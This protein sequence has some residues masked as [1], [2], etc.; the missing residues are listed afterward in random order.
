MRLLPSCGGLQRM[1][2]T[3]P[4]TITLHFDAPFVTFGNRVTQ[5][6][7]ASVAYIHPKRYTETVGDEGVERHPVGTGPWRFVEHFPGQR[8][9]YEAVTSHW[10]TVPHFQRLVFLRV[11]DIAT[12]IAML[13]AGE[14]DVIEMSGE[15]IEALQ[16]AGLRTLVMPNVAWVW[17][18]LGGQ[19]P[20]RPTYDPTVPWA[21]PD[22][23]RAR[24]VRL[25]LNLAIDKE[26][27]IQ[28]ILGGVGTP[29]G[30]VNFTRPIPGQRALAQPYPYDPSRAKAILAEAGY[31][32]GFPITMYLTAWPGRGYL[33]DVGEAVA[34]YW[35]RIGLKVTRRPVDRAVFA[36]DFR[37][38]PIQEWPW[39]TRDLF[40]LLSPGNCLY[41]LPTARPPCNCSSSIQRS[42][43]W[44]INSEQR[45]IPASGRESCVKNLAPAADVYTRGQYWPHTRRG[46]VGPRIGAWPLI[47]GHT[48]LH[49]WEYVTHGQ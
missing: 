26:A 25:A 3:D 33:P 40:S 39:R 28:Q 45:P 30:T 10:R 44:S 11:P 43:R 8:I 42:M 38:A 15:Y 9:V 2:V 17:V 18:V 6:L 36:N 5:G 34:S 46:G 19:W 41:V 7:F 13:R 35:E 32:Q 37:P 29:G 14:A 31:P 47:P 23:E 21:L 20:A 4:W 12:R 49:N 1:E 48:G 16:K 22:A 27:I 24:K